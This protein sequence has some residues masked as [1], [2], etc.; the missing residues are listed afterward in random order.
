MFTSTVQLSSAKYNSRLLVRVLV[1]VCTYKVGRYAVAESGCGSF[2]Y[3]ETIARGT[4]MS[5]CAKTFC[6]SIAQY[7]K[8]QSDRS[9]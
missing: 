8:E 6:N 7:D 1:N 3:F 5:S 4:V 2:I 9:K